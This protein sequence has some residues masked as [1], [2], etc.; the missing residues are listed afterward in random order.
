[1]L[2]YIWS[3]ALNKLE[4]KGYETGDYEIF[5]KLSPLKPDSPRQIASIK[6]SEITPMQTKMLIFNGIYLLVIL[7]GFIVIM[8]LR[9]DKGD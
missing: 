1:M 8:D 4:I 3:T 5:D 6:F 2:I 7:I 9:T